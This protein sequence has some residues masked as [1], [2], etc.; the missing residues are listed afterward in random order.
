M[1]KRKTGTTTK[2]DNYRRQN[3]GG[4][5]K[6]RAGKV[7]AGGGGVGGVRWKRN[8]GEKVTDHREGRGKNGTRK[9]D[10]VFERNAG[11]RRKENR[12]KGW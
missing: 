2:S 5:S 9:N 3:Y 11:G 8:D 1:A 10:E 4:Q 7:K 6:L 12:S